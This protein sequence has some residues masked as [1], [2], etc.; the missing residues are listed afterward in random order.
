MFIPSQAMIFVFGYIM[1][2]KSVA[3]MAI[4]RPCLEYG[5]L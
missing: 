4:V 1:D 5:M 3:N 2:V